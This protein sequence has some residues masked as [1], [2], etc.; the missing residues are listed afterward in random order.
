MHNDPS[1]GISGKHIQTN[2]VASTH[3]NIYFIFKYQFKITKD[4]TGLIMNTDIKKIKL[5]KSKC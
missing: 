4:G 5:R 1:L 2:K 3:Q